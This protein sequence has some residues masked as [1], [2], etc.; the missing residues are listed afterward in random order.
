MLKWAVHS[1]Q[2]VNHMRTNCQLVK[3]QF[4]YNKEI[5]M[6]LNL[7]TESKVTECKRI[8]LTSFTQK[9]MSQ[10]LQQEWTRLCQT[11]FPEHVSEM[12]EMCLDTRDAHTI[13]KSN[14]CDL[15]SSCHIGFCVKMVRL[16]LLHFVTFDSV[17]LLC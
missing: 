9:S 15:I 13:L 14:D 17:T 3:K 4:F 8:S 2:I 5:Y 12:P 7:V 10:V 6:N 1:G 16:I 11:S